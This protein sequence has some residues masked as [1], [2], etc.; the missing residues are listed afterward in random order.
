MTLVAVLSE[1]GER[2]AVNVAVE[3]RLEPPLQ[4]MVTTLSEGEGEELRALRREVA[5]A[6]TNFLR[7]CAIPTAPTLRSISCTA[8]GPYVRIVKVYQAA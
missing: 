8:T 1:E 5:R 7:F 4:E 3:V 6:A 2:R